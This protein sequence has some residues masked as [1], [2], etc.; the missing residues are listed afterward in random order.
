MDAD[1]GIF[2]SLNPGVH[3]S[4]PDVIEFEVTGGV[5]TVNT[6]FVAS[7]IWSQHFL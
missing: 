4:Q 1:Q 5:L 6:A 2:Y 7:G 3:L